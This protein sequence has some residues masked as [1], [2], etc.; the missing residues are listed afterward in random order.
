MFRIQGAFGPPDQ[1]SKDAGDASRSKGP[2]LG[3]R[4]GAEMDLT[5]KISLSAARAVGGSPSEREGGRDGGEMDFTQNISLGA[6]RAEGGS[7]S[8]REGPPPSRVGLFHK[9]ACHLQVI[10]PPRDSRSPSP[11]VSPPG[12]FC[13]MEALLSALRAIDAGELDGAIRLGARVFRH[14]GSR[15]ADLL[16]TAEDLARGPS[17]NIH[18]KRPV[19]GA[20]DGGSHKRQKIAHAPNPRN[21]DGAMAVDDH[22]PF[23]ACFDDD[24][25]PF[26]DS[27]S[28]SKNREAEERGSRSA[29]L[30]QSR[31]SPARPAQQIDGEPLA[32]CGGDEADLAPPQDKEDFGRMAID[33]DHR[34]PSDDSFCESIESGDFQGEEQ[35]ASA[36]RIIRK[37]LPDKAAMDRDSPSYGSQSGSHVFEWSPPLLW[38]VG[39]PSGRGDQS[40]N[41]LS[42]SRYE[43][44]RRADHQAGGHYKR[45]QI[46]ALRLQSSPSPAGDREEELFA[47]P[48]TNERK[49]PPDYEAG[50]DPKRRKIMHRIKPDI[51]LVLS[52]PLAPE[53][54]PFHFEG[55]IL[56]P[57]EAAA[58]QGLVPPAL[59]APEGPPFHFEGQILPPPEEA[60][61]QGLVPPAPL[62]GQA[63]AYQ[64]LVLP[65]QPHAP[66]S[67][68]KRNGNPDASRP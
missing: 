67:S 30:E 35:G 16:S 33:D 21:G 43:R 14:Q 47:P 44:K 20:V 29:N 38:R 23:G 52:G 26:A 6:P 54:S 7:P 37:N 62:P 13:D 25:P 3:P 68:G 11:Q 55:Q 39:P 17:V 65:L 41:S 5:K 58:Y 10:Q 51:D 46:M 18:V 64:G 28:G 40:R 45:R 24:R 48:P 59:L 66:V 15:S 8:E 60:A 36:E 9:K 1:L 42:D 56:P 12:R 50:P 61:D 19:E 27:F 57:P 32:A 63:A 2:S 22:V 31:N 53:G 4:R 34:P 49:R